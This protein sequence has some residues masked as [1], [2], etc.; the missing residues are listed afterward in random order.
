MRR[1]LTYLFWLLNKALKVFDYE[2]LIKKKN[3]VNKIDLHDLILVMANLKHDLAILV[4]GAYDFSTVDPIKSALDVE[5][6]KI[7]LVEAN[8]KVVRELEQRFQ[9][10]PNVK[11]YEYGITEDKKEN[12]LYTF[13]A[14]YHYLD[15]SLEASSSLILEQLISFHKRNEKLFEGSGFEIDKIVKTPINSITISDFLKK[16]SF[17]RIDILQ[18]DIEGLDGE[19]ILNFP[20]DRLSPS[21]IIFEYRFLNI[22]SIHDVLIK[23]HTYGYVTKKIDSDNMVAINARSLKV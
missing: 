9:H 16:Y 11:I 4:I 22:K 13:P 21:L 23:L 2:I 3:E 17:T 5:S 6:Q 18:I 14:E 10:L 8:P 1:T 19:V 12:F 7:H 20:L 15:H